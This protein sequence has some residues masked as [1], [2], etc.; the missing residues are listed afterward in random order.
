MIPD[1]STTFGAVALAVVFVVGTARIVRLVV[2][3][4]FPPILA[5][6]VWYED[7]TSGGWE[8]LLGCPWCF[9]VW[10]TA[11]NALIG[12]GMFSVGWYEGWFIGNALLTASYASALLV[13]HDEDG[14]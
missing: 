10:A 13:F 8:T 14:A 3:D 1:V 7:H 4:T 2:A 5:L 9:G 6:R 12:W 11:F